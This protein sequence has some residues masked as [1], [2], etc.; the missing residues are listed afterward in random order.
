MSECDW[1]VDLEDVVLLRHGDAQAGSLVLHN[2]KEYVP[3]VDEQAL[4]TR[5]K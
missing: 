1:I 2:I 3:E 5:R 4:R